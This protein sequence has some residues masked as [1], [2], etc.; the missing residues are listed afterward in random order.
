VRVE[1]AFRLTLALEPKASAAAESYRPD[2]RM[3]ECSTSTK[4]AT[5]GDASLVGLCPAIAP[6]YRHGLADCPPAGC[7][8]PLPFVGSTRC[9]ACCRSRVSWAP[10]SDSS[11]RC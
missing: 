10:S 6:Q 1:G 8:G 4:T 3:A 11:R 7:S 2:A 5:D 9:D